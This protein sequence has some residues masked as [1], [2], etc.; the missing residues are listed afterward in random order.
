MTNKIKSM[1]FYVQKK[2]QL[3]LSFTLFWLFI[4]LFHGRVVLFN[5]FCCPAG[6]NTVALAVFY[7]LTL[8]CFF[9]FIIFHNHFIHFNNID[10]LAAE[11]FKDVLVINNFYSVRFCWFGSFS[12]NVFFSSSVESRDMCLPQSLKYP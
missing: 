11:P 4:F 6:S 2:E 12:Y 1:F 8:P 9:S 7:C 10:F 3:L 5:N